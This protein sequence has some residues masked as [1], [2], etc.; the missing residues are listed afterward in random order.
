MVFLNL[1]KSHT[2]YEIGC[3]VKVWNRGCLSEDARHYNQSN[4]PAKLTHTNYERT[5]RLKINGKRPI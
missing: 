3:I 1:N 5:L 4:T 2:N